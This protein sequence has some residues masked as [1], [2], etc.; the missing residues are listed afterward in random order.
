MVVVKIDSINSIKK[1]FWH[2][3]R[4]NYSLE[5]Y[6]I[7][8]ECLNKNKGHCFGELLSQNDNEKVTVLDVKKTADRFKEFNSLWDVVM[9]YYDIYSSEN[10]DK[11]LGEYLEEMELNNIYYYELEC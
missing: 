7:I 3:N 8:L 5:S 10:K 4:D 6:S 2:Y 9:E 11:T 1:L